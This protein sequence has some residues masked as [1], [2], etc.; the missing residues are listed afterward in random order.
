MAK[1]SPDDLG[2]LGER[3]LAEWGVGTATLAA[4]LRAWLG[5][6]VTTDVAIAHRLG[7]QASEASAAMLQDL[8]AHAADKRVRREAKRALYRLGQRGVTGPPAPPAIRAS[9]LL[10]AVI[11]GWTSAIDGHGDQLL[12]LARPQPGGV[13]HLF[14]IANDPAGLREVVLQTVTRKALRALRTELERR[15]QVTLVEREWRHVDFLMR[16]AF[17]WARERGTR[18]EGDYPASRA[19]FAR[20]P[21]SEE[22]APE[23]AARLGAALAAEPQALASSAQLLSEPEFRTWFRTGEE[24]RAFLD[25]LAA[26]RD[27]PLLLNEVQ[28][29]ERYEAI[30]LR[31]VDTLFD[32]SDRSSWARRLLEMAGYLAAARR[33]QAAARAAAV[34]EALAA[35]TAPHEVPFCR[36]LVQASLAFFFQQAAQDE[37]ERQRSS[38]VLTPQE[39][40]RQRQP[41]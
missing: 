33:P 23:E 26:V 25:E 2:A 19:Q 7:E 4:D 40:L 20:Q 18:M 3:R 28:Q 30:T 13:V 38:L 9:P 35:S 11:E 1:P 21:P 37:A 6:D 10:G 8:A 15:H 17:G 32:G 41:R 29:R 22:A 27:S 31:A 5:K 24:L 36:Q 39:A 34:A 12:W 16:R 14:A